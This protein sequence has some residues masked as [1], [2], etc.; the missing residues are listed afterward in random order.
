M[1][2]PTILLVSVALF[3]LIFTAYL[4]VKQ[5]SF[6][7]TSNL[8]ILALGIC[9]IIIILFT[10]GGTQIGTDLS[11]I[12]SNSVPKSPIEV[13]AALFKEPKDSCVRIVQIKD[14]LPYV[15]CCIWMQV[16]TCPDE[17]NRLS[18][19]KEYKG[20]LHRA[21]DSLTYM[22]P[23]ADRPVW[24]IPQML[25]DTIIELEYKR[26]EDHIQSLL[27]NTDSTV[28]YICDMAR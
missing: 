2:I 7:K 28:L 18:G 24:W 13:Y 4:F 6:L 11:R 23:F 8:L 16:E 17:L 1:L 5:K 20:T 25:G 22:Q 21:S 15:D 10:R 14:Q 27:F 19:M 3:L 12:F 9:C 26:D